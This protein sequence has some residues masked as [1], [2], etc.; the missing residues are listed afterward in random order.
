MFINKNFK[1]KQLLQFTGWH[2]VWLTAW[3]KDADLVV[4]D[5]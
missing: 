1:L 2:L 3:A 4:K 5:L